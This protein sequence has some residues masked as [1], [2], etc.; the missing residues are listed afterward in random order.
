MY[1]VA[2]GL[3]KWP[4][5]YKDIPDVTL[6]LCHEKRFGVWMVFTGLNA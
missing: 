5:L 2:S 1:T 4:Q 3:L 6:F